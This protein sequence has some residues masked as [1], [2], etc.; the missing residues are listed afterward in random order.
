MTAE[1][2]AHRIMSVLLAENPYN[3][4]QLSFVFLLV[5]IDFVRSLGAYL[6]LS[7]AFVRICIRAARN[8]G[9]PVSP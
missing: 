8:P 3:L 5:F 2:T 4:H 7:E 1:V 6:E 9:L